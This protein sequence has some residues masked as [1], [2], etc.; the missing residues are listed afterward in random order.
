MIERKCFRMKCLRPFLQNEQ[1][2]PICFIMAQIGFHRRYDLAQKWHK[3]KEGRGIRTLRAAGPA[4]GAQG[5]AE[6][7]TDDTS[8]RHHCNVTLAILIV[9]WLLA[10]WPLGQ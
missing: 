1:N 10:T 5:R 4:G 3:E 2:R 9:G 6:R 7:M 8:G